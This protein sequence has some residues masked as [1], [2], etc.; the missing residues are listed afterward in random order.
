MGQP[1]FTFPPGRYG[2]RRAPRRP[3]RLVFAVVLALVLAAGLAITFK[4]YD[5]YTANKVHSRVM[6]FTVVSDNAVRVQF[7]IN[8]KSG[9]EA[10]CVVRA[11]SRDGAEVG[12]AQ[13]VVAADSPATV[14]YTLT[15]SK[16]AVT[17]EVLGCKR[18]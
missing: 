7:E 9:S 12:R 8:K 3:R 10:T 11:R 13:F 17:G 5:T 6:G 14:V 16:K 2:R 1:E 18:R 15:T 4:L